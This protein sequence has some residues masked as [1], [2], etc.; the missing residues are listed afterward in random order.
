MPAMSQGRIR[1]TIGLLLLVYIFNF[2]DRQI[3]GILAQSIS[4]DLHLSDLQIGL[5]TGTAFALFY[6]GLGIPIARI[7]DRPS[8][9]RINIIAICLAIW[10]AMTVLCGAASSFVQMF[11]ARVGVG[12]GEA[13][14]TPPAHSLIAELSPPEKRASA[15]SFYQLGPPIGGLIAMVMGGYLADTIGWRWA[16]VVVGAPGILLAVVVYLMLRDPRSDR[17]VVKAAQVPQV[18][19]REAFKQILESRAN[20]LILLSV[21][22]AATVNFGIMIWGAIYLQR[23]F[24][25][26]ATQTGLW[27]GLANGLGSGLGVWYGGQLGDRMRAKGKQHLMTV[28]AIGLTL[29]CPFLMAGLLVPDWRLAVLLFFPGIALLWLHVGPGYSAVQGLVPPTSRATA[30]ATILLVQ[31]LFGLGLGSPLIGEMSDQLKPQFGADSVRWVLLV[32]VGVATL[33]A[34]WLQWRSRRYLPEELD[35]DWGLAG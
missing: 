31:N 10:S 4:R 9:S 34:A 6:T 1:L 3:V 22:F 17:S 21:A 26:T 13:G 19:F 12:I 16:F 18:S 24:G 20:R 11:L 7:A 28:P 32:L 25:L 35:R 5:M 29:C 15:L 2:L 33:A 23:S 14:G 8:N 27:F 30:S